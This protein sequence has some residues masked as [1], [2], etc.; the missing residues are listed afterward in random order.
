M[1]LNKM[2]WTGFLTLAAGVMTLCG[3]ENLLRN[4]EFASK[5]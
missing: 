4:P 1:K 5:D 3:G 2:I